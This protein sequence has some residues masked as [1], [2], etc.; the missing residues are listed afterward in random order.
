MGWHHNPFCPPPWSLLILATCCSS[1]YRYC[2]GIGLVLSFSGPFTAVQNHQKIR[3]RNLCILEE[4]SHLLGQGTKSSENANKWFRISDY[5]NRNRDE[6]GVETP[7]KDVRNSNW[8]PM[9]DIW[10]QSVCCAQQDSP[11]K[12]FNEEVA[13]VL[14]PQSQ[15]RN[16]KWEHCAHQLHRKFC[17]CFDKS[18]GEQ[19]VSCID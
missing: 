15:R 8:W 18:F 5:Q 12:C 16:Y 6:D 4:H 1:L 3:D 9:N 17:W 19:W 10:R 7:V 14:P 11:I 2:V 13:F